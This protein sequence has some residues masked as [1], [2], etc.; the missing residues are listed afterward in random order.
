MDAAIRAGADFAP[1]ILAGDGEP[2]S[3]GV[4][5]GGTRILGI[6]VDAVD[7]VRFRRVMAR[8]PRLTTRCFTEG[9]RSY[10][11]ISGDPGLRLATRFAAKEAVM[12]CLGVGIT[13]VAFREI[14]VVRPG[15]D[16]PILS[17]SGRARAQ[18]EVMGITGWHLSLT[19]TDTLAMAFVVAEGAA[20]RSP[21]A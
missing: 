19:H 15:R 1:V 4:P 8:R 11:G 12:K 3:S 2:A 7:V 14:E 9:E 10:A 13:A 6:G 18:A 20:D 5:R 17:L 21:S 16:Q